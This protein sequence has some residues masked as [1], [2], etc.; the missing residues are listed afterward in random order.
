[1]MVHHLHLAFRAMWIHVSVRL[2]RIR[3]EWNVL[4]HGRVSLFWVLTWVPILSRMRHRGNCIEL[5]IVRRGSFAW[6]GSRRPRE[7]S[8]KH[9]VPNG[10]HISR[11]QGRR[12]RLGWHF[13]RN[14]NAVLLGHIACI[15]IGAYAISTKVRT[16]RNE[17]IR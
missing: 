17:P 9:G 5:G 7:L 1:M 13:R 3:K 8:R 16:S 11:L 4:G 15:G 2:R 6:F 12:G 10:S 14:G